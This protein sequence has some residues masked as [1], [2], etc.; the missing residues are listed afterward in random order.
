MSALRVGAEVYAVELDGELL[1]WDPAGEALHR[2]N[3]FATRI[4]S[5]IARGAT[6]TEIASTIAGER[7]QATDVVAR[8]VETLVDELLAYGVLELR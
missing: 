1:V 4:W 8:D 7:S 3:T 2:L 5:E 6:P